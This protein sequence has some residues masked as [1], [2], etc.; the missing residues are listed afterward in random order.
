MNEELDLDHCF[1]TVTAI[2]K[3]AGV[4]SIMLFTVF[5]LLMYTVTVSLT[6]LLRPPGL[7]L[8]SRPKG[9]CFTFGRYFIFSGVRIAP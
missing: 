9:L 5:M 1:Q 7:D 2:A 3:E 6:A 4:V 8:R